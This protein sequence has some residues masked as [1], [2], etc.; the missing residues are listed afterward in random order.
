MKHIRLTSAAIL[1]GLGAA[2]PAHAATMMMGK[3]PAVACR[4]GA[5]MDVARGEVS[6]ASH[7]DSIASCTEALNGKLNDADRGATLANRGI[8]EAAAGDSNAA[9]AD[10]NEALARDPGAANVYVN[11]GAAFLKAGRFEE[12]RA[13]FDHALTLNA[14]SR[15]VVYFDRGMAEEKLGQLS[16]AYHDYSRAL[17][18]SP[19]FTPAREQ[20]ARF[21]VTS[22]KYAAN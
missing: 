1:L 18:L 17:N 13:D 9:L 4:D 5:A 3:T 20:L 16:A 22:P 10:F 8:V 14:G 21:T 7:H 11:R 15:A 12:A 19:D 6:N 2:M